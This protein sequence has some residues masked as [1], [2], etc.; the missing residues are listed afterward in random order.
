MALNN[1][2]LLLALSAVAASMA[3]AA[4]VH[5]QF[6]GGRAAFGQRSRAEPVQFREFFRS[7]FWGG[8]GGGGGGGFYDPYNPF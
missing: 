3:L 6:A 7:P 4:P 2:P 5:A 1:R 8:G